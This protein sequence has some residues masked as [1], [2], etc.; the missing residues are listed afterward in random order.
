MIVRTVEFIMVGEELSS[1]P[2]WLDISKNHAVTMAVHARQLR[3]WSK[4]LR[5]FVHYLSPLGKKLRDQVN[6]TRS[7]V[8]PIVQ[9]R[10]AE[11]A[12]CLAKGVDPPVYVDSIQWFEEAA[13]GDW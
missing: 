10:R 5:P 4:A 3:L 12:A 2:E 8:E 11:R 1:N 9:K 6:K 7:L 13:D